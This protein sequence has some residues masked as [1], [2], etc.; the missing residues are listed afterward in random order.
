M[1]HPNSLIRQIRIAS[2][3]LNYVQQRNKI[4]TFPI[5]LSLKFLKKFNTQE[6]WEGQ[7]RTDWIRMLRFW[8]KQYKRGNFRGPSPTHLSSKNRSL[9]PFP[10]NEFGLIHKTIPSFCNRFPWWALRSFHNNISIPTIWLWRL[11]LLTIIE[12]QRES[13]S[14]GNVHNHFPSKAR[15]LL[16]KFPTPRPPYFFGLDTISH[17]TRWSLL[18]SPFPSQ[19]KALFIFS[20]NLAN[21]E[22]ITAPIWV[23]RQMLELQV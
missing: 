11:N 10:H 1:P 13:C 8:D 19:K 3:S 23:H 6:D 20:N 4:L 7:Q 2:N 21:F 15:F 5:S 14:I 18:P 22:G 16:I 9:S 12:C 17:L